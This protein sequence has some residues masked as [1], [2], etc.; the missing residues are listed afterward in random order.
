MIIEKRRFTKNAM[1]E[2]AD[3]AKTLKEMYNSTGFISIDVMGQPQVH[4]SYEYF[5]ASFSEWERKEFTYNSD[6]LFTVVDDV[7]YFCLEH[8]EREPEIIEPAKPVYQLPAIQLTPKKIDVLTMMI[9]FYRLRGNPDD[10]FNYF[11]EALK[12]ELAQLKE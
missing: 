1:E 9:D 6:K 8:V 2:I 12:R 10:D 3:A 4:V 7:Q 11:L 5:T